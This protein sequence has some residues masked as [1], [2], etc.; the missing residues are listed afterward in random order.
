MRTTYT[1]NEE[2]GLVEVCAVVFSPDIRDRCPIEF[3]FNVSFS[4]GDSTAVASAG[5]YSFLLA[6]STT[7]VILFRSLPQIMLL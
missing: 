6:K 2:D 1:V 5:K 3:P 4:T 7:G